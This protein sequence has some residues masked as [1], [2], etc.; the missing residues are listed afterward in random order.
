MSND[1]RKG[2]QPAGTRQPQGHRPQFNDAANQNFRKGAPVAEVTFEGL[3]PARIAKQEAQ[4]ALIQENDITFCIGPAGTGKTHVAMVQAV[5]ALKSG[6]VDTI[7]LA[8][9]AVEAGETIGFLPG[10][11][12]E[13]M[14]PYMRPLY[15]E[16][17]KHYGRGAYRTMIRDE[18]NNPDGI[19]E[20]APVGTMRGRTFA[21]AFVIVDEAQN[22]KRE[23]LKMALTRLGPGSKMV[24][25]GD[26]GQ[27]DLSPKEL[28]GLMDFIEKLEGVEGVA[29]HRY[30]P[31][32][33]MRHPTVERLVNRLEGKD[34]V[35]QPSSKHPAP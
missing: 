19:V 21:K 6:A 4:A 20:V 31:E 30:G 11:Q 15:D 12:N 13:K 33:V 34:Q 2:R 8:R 35:N 9:P 16:L 18:Q 27:I 23:E 5:E 7:L 29:V 26:P 17:D 10:G 24:I 1:M 22:L 32:D 25:T 14:A 28:S 3:T